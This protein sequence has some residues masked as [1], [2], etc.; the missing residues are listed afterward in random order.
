ML[1][2]MTCPLSDGQTNAATLV[3]SAVWFAAPACWPPCG[4]AAA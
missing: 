3:A 2:G 1:V 4:P